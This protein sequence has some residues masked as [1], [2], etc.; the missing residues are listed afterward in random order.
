MM[1][2]PSQPALGDSGDSRNPNFPTRADM[3]SYGLVNHP[4][5]PGL[6]HDPRCPRKRPPILIAGWDRQ[7]LLSCPQ[8]GRTA[9]A[10]DQRA[11]PE[12]TP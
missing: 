4:N 10:P 12:R 3:K 7:P 6:E 1:I 8:C 5:H 2:P 11:N 9:S